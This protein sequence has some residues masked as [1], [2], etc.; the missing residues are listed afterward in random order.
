MTSMK[1]TLH[2]GCVGQH[3]CSDDPEF[4]HWTFNP[5]EVTCPTCLEVMERYRLFQIKHWHWADGLGV[6]PKPQ[7]RFPPGEMHTSQE[8]GRSK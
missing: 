2:N 6:G 1:P 8:G 4:S 5:N 7:W 3:C